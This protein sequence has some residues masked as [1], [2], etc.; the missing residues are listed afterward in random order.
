M[1]DYK[2][3]YKDI[4]VNRKGISENA[5]MTTTDILYETIPYFNY[6]VVKNGLELTNI[7]NNNININIH[8]PKYLE[9]TGKWLSD[10]EFKNKLKDANILGG[11]GKFEINLDEMN[12]PIQD[13]TIENLMYYNVK[14]LKM[15]DII[16]F[17]TND[18]LPLCIVNIGSSYINDYILQENYGCGV[19]LE[20]HKNPHFHMPLN[21]NSGGGI[22][23]AKQIEQDKYQI[24]CF[25]IPY[26][27]ATYI[28]PYTI[29]NDCFLIGEYY[30][31]YSK[32]EPFSTCLLRNKN[33]KIINIII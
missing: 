28:P 18:H 14:L 24:S 16:S 19:Y 29:H 25:R 13:A 6:K 23:L 4:I 21:E 27:Y 3:K 17:E 26:G 31:I 20:Y 5:F 9:F 8:I 11:F 32:S 15:N 12:I 10:I 1:V 7:P 22:I 2:Y 30:V 33:D